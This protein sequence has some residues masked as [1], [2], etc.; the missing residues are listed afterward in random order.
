MEQELNPEVSDIPPGLEDAL[1]ILA[2][3]SGTTLRVLYVKLENGT[4]MPFLGPLIDQETLVK[5]ESLSLGEQILI[6]Y[7]DWDEGEE[8]ESLG[9]ENCPSEERSTKVH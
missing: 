1:S 9:G 6:D 2:P 8:E 7:D 4:T 5:I 3:E